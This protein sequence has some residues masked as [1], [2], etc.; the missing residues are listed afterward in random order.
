MK[1]PYFH[2]DAFVADGLRGNPAGVCPLERWLDEPA[3]QGIAA[4]NNL[5]ETAFFVGGDGE[6]DLR[7]FTPTVEV[8]LCGHATVASAAVVCERL[9]PGRERVRFRSAS[10][11]LAVERR[12]EIYVLDFPAR[13]PE[14]V[15]ASEAAAVV[16]AL[17]ARPEIVL[18]ARDVLAVFASEDDVR[19]LAPDLARVAALERFAVIVT[20]PGREADFVSRFFA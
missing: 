3:M 4:E 11:P 19:G 14:P 16:A 15:A 5:S 7:W 2:V 12:G 8:D 13:P 17:G 1:L 18:A 10:G 9:E 20:A 6:Y